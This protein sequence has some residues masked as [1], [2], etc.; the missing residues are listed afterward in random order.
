MAVIEV[1]DLTKIYKRYV[2]KEGILES[3]KGL[4]TRQYVPKRAVDGITFSINQGE[5]VGLIG[6]N[7]AGKTTLIKMLTGIISPTSGEINVLG[8]YPNDLKPEFKKKYA[9]VMGQKSQLF[10]ELTVNDTLRLY[11]EIYDISE[12]RFCQNRKYF[13]DLLGINRLLDVQ[14]RTLSLGERMKMEL[15]VALMHEPEILFLDEPT[16]GLDAIA[17]KQIRE[18]L[19]VINKEKNVTILL[20][21]HYMED[22]KSMCQRTIVINNGSKIYDGNTSYLFEKYQKNKCINVLFDNYLEL[23]LGLEVEIIVDKPSKKIIVVDQENAGRVIREILKY[24][25]RDISIETE[26]IGTIVERIYQE[27]SNDYEQV[28]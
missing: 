5:F 21:S 18:Y 15:M 9:I 4:F 7:G 27:G 11:K 25:P 12:E 20:T 17:A 6:P 14:V 1:K 10:Y 19:K 8:Y 23:N 22:I 16:I 2:K 3:V 24:N 26:D 13:A 28:H